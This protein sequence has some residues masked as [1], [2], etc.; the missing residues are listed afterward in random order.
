MMPTPRKLALLMSL[1]GFGALLGQPAYA[2]TQ[3]QAAVPLER[4]VATAAR[5]DGEGETTVAGASFLLAADPLA[6]SPLPAAAPSIAVAATID[7]AAAMPA[8]APM[9]APPPVSRR[10]FRRSGDGEQADTA[11][12]PSSFHGAEAEPAAT[13]RHPTGSFP[14]MTPA[15][16]LHGHSSHPSAPQAPATHRVGNGLRVRQP[17][18]PPNAHGPWQ[19]I[20]M[21]GG[22]PKPPPADDEPLP[23]TGP[24]LSA[25][26]GAAA[27]ASVAGDGRTA[28]AFA[29]VR[30]T[31]DS[32]RRHGAY[33]PPG[34]PPGAE[35]RV[36]RPAAPSFPAPRDSGGA[37]I[38][39]IDLGR[40]TAVDVDLGVA[41][42][43][44]GATATAGAAGRV[45]SIDLELDFGAAVAVDV[46]R[47]RSAAVDADAT[48]VAAVD[49]DLGRAA[50]VDLDLGVSAAVDVD[51]GAAAAIDIDLDL[52]STTDQ[53]VQ[54]L[55]AAKSGAMRDDRAAPSPLRTGSA[56]A[57]FGV[58]LRLDLDLELNINLDFERA[59]APAADVGPRSRTGA[60]LAGRGG[61]AGGIVMPSASA[62]A[63]PA[64][65]ALSAA[66]AGRLPFG[67]EAWQA[68]LQAS[69]ANGIS[70][71]A[72][73]IFIAS[74]TT[75]PVPKSMA[76][77]QQA[78]SPQGHFWLHEAPSAD[79]SS[80]ATRRHVLP[81][82][83]RAALASGAIEPAWPAA[84]APHDRFEPAAGPAHGALGEL[85]A[86][87]ESSLDEVR[88]GFQTDSG[89]QI[90]FGIERAVYINGGLVTTPSLN[91]VESTGAGGVQVRS[92]PSA[93]TTGNLA[94]IQNGAGNT[95]T[96]GPLSP[97]AVATVIQN[98][99]DGQS[100]QS[101]TK[102]D[103]TVN[104]LQMIRS[105][106]FE[107]SLRGAII[108]SLRR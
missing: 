100:I 49:I 89:L 81:L 42:A 28:G 73:P 97:S 56:A 57:G 4:L 38:V 106:N 40:G 50:V 24:G 91:I 30:P 88:G 48:S 71:P 14:S 12:E 75:R 43:D 23:G 77:R 26:G 104:S 27:G 35:G 19:S 102:I 64:R 69:A 3:L 79:D 98:T 67:S 94:L 22:D 31:A 74:D 53:A 96:T 105:Q 90:S 65:P 54:P 47:S 36:W 99:L 59:A 63:A 85:M 60:A 95:F 37:A 25:S 16:E 61:A 78:A 20:S 29:V 87:S 55:H 72:E 45:A 5:G 13:S 80:A 44:P 17:K 52:T 39:D 84:L 108:D 9:P 83:S 82:P 2:R 34:K 41:A 11:V 18:G 8:V 86:V 103:A 68:Q 1:A 10:P 46:G 93:V 62:A 51:L 32:G 15:P 101:V 21:S 76:S 66:G 92:L 107:S 58:D 7:V 70:M 33:M 6:A